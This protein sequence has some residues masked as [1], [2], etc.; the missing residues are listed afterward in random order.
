MKSLT[1]LCLELT[2]ECGSICGVSTTHDEKTIVERAEHEGV[3]FLTITLPSYA[4]DFERSLALGRIDDGLFLPFRK[5]KSGLPLLFGGFLRLVFDPCNDRHI[6]DDPSVDAIFFVRQ[7]CL[8]FGKIFALPSNKRQ[9]EAMRQYIMIDQEV[10]TFNARSI[11]AA[12]GPRRGSTGLSPVRPRQLQHQGDAGVLGHGRHDFEMGDV[13]GGGSVLPLHRFCEGG[14]DSPRTDPS[15]SLREVQVEL[16]KVLLLLYRGPLSALDGASFT[17]GLLGLGEPRHGSGATA[18]GLAGN[19]KLLPTTYPCRLEREF[20][21]SEWHVHNHRHSMAVQSRVHFLGLAQEI[22]VKVISV[23]KTMKT[24]RIIA[25][26]PT[27]M[28]YAQQAIMRPLVRMLED[29]PLVSPMIGFTDQT[30]NRGMAC[31]GSS[32]GGLA[33]LDLSEA[34]D[35]VSI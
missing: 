22:P 3:S 27:A 16:R 30:P 10:S 11:K 14:P 5:D 20:P 29:D 25:E 34:S 35:R 6:H 9:Y 26:E 18:D 31:E 23:P 13:L 15:E 28:Q 24:S 33:T 21:F 7:I 32:T 1:H 8:A 2:R 4:K 19:Q 12:H 17:D